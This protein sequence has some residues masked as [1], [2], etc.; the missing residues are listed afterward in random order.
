MQNMR[1]GQAVIVGYD[2]E[3]TASR[4]IYSVKLINAGDGGTYNLQ[5]VYNMR[6]ADGTFRE[7]RPCF[8]IGDTVEVKYA[9]FKFGKMQGMDVHLYQDAY[10]GIYNRAK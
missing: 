1:R 2:S 4:I 7:D 9:P 6:K 10:R 3:S 5:G 8:K